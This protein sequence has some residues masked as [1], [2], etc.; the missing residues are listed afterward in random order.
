MSHNK[1]FTE[2]DFN[3]QDVETVEKYGRKASGLTKY[4]ASKTL[5]EKGAPDSRSENASRDF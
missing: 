1:V 4:S 3:D 2:A 5:A